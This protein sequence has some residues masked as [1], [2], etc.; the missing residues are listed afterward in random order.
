MDITDAKNPTTKPFW[1][2]FVSLV[3]VD[4]VKRI[5]VHTVFILVV[6]MISKYLGTNVFSSVITNV[7]QWTHHFFRSITAKK[8][9]Q[10]V[11]KE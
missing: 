7:M 2:A 9:I 8:I 10:T 4:I 1:R 11:T 5:I 3:I 6:D